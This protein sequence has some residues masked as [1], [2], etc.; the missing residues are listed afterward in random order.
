MIDLN[1][2]LTDDLSYLSD[3]EGL[4]RRS[5]KHNNSLDQ[6]A[7]ALYKAFLTCSFT[8]K[9]KDNL[10]PF[11]RTLF[12]TL[13]KESKKLWMNNFFELWEDAKDK[14]TLLSIIFHTEKGND[15]F[16]NLSP[17]ERVLYS[18]PWINPM[19]KL[20]INE[21]FPRMALLQLWKST[22]REAKLTLYEK[23]MSV[24]NTLG[25]EYSISLNELVKENDFLTIKKN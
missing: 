20:G 21:L 4:K 18:T 24:I 19:I 16:N 3:F 22:P 1:N 6:I 12:N 11:C 2:Y 14:E 7:S 5:L 17:V 25:S 15:I 23:I 13:S 9:Q 8:Q 10:A